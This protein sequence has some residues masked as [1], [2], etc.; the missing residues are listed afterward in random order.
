L[1]LALKKEYGTVEANDA[2]RSFDL[3][4]R[5]EKIYPVLALEEVQRA[6]DV[7]RPRNDRPATFGTKIVEEKGIQ[8]MQPREGQAERKGN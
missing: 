4:A 1:L 3:R 6:A 2:I 7:P 8:L 5:V